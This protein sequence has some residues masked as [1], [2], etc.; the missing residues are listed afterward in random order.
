MSDNENIYALRHS[1]AH[2]LATVVQKRWPTAQ[3]G[4]GPVVDDGFYYDILIPDTNIGEDDLATLEDDMRKLSEAGE[5]FEKYELPIDEALEW[6]KQNN[7]PFKTELLNDLKREGTTNA[8]ELTEIMGMVGALGS[9]GGLGTTAAEA[10]VGSVSF[11]KNGD[12]TD[13]CRGPHVASTS[14]VKHF[15]LTKIAGAYWRGDETKPQ[16]QRIYGVAFETAEA[17]EEYLKQQDEARERDHRKLGQALD[18]F[19]FS[20]LVGSGLPLFTARGTWLRQLLGDYSQQLRQKLGFERI[21]T[22]HITKY[23]LYKKSGHWDKFG[24]ELFLVK[25]QESSDEFAMK[26]MNCPHHAQIY[27]SDQRSYRDLPIRYMENT[28]DYRDEKTGELHGLSRVRSL[29]QDDSH[30]FCRQDQIEEEATKLIKAAQE[31]YSTLGMELKFRLSFR[32]NSD[33]YLGD[34]E[35]WDSTQTKIKDIAEKNGLDFYIEE[36]EAAFYGPKIDFVATDAI[37][38]EWQT[39]TVQ[40]D[41]VQPSRFELVYTADDGS[42]QTPVM[43]HCA[44]LGTIERFLSVYI[45]HVNGHFPFWLA[46]EQVRIVTVNDSVNEYVDKLTAKLDSVVLMD[47]LKYNPVRYKVDNANQSLGKKIHAA[48]TMKIPVIVIV[49]PKDMQAG[50]VSLRINGQESK[51]SLEEVSAVLEK[52]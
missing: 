29:T 18:L 13:L 24:D 49:G 31:L 48:E 23:D 19:T 2:M 40:I 11:Y 25:S 32:D 35:L 42:Q 34:S 46:P 28:T 47:P 10:K 3:F 20:D 50:E 41:I 6:A 27:A 17:L 39:A 8:K 37:G 14:D 26:P 4:V 45:E 5:A 21:W 52:L 51:V 38:R 16:M 9:A 44:L 22:P 30:V 33:Q 36:G 1:A 15:N 43:I 7:Q 12:F